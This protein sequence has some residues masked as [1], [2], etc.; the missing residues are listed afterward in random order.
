MRAIKRPQ[1]LHTSK[2]VTVT[3]KR[4]IVPVKGHR[5]K[6]TLIIHDDHVDVLKDGYNIIERT[7]YDDSFITQANELVKELNDE[8]GL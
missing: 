1:A 7:I 8:Y 2:R 5:M 4:Y 6:K 3:I